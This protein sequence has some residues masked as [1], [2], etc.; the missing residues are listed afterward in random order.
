MKICGNTEYTT[1]FWNCCG[2]LLSFSLDFLAMNLFAGWNDHILFC[3]MSAEQGI[4][5]CHKSLWVYILLKERNSLSCS[6]QMA[7]S[8][9]APC[10]LI[11][12]RLCKSHFMEETKSAQNDKL[13][14]LISVPQSWCAWSTG[15]IRVFMIFEQHGKEATHLDTL[16][17]KLIN[18]PIAS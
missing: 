13:I 9:S 2:D 8:I 17:R 15:L 14:L 11:L 16:L 3:H 1:E 7:K 18:I 4:V 10:G 6:P 5:P 12:I